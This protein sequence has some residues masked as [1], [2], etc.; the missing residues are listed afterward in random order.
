MVT[1]I[2]HGKSHQGVG[3]AGQGH[4]VLAAQ[5]LTHL[6]QQKVGLEFVAKLKAVIVF[7]SQAGAC[8]GIC[9]IADP[10]PQL[11]AWQRLKLNADRNIPADARVATVGNF[12][13]AKLVRVEQVRLG[14]G[15]FAGVISVAGGEGQVSLEDGCGVIVCA[16]EGDVAEQVF[17]AGIKLE[18][19]VCLSFS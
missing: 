15:Q 2:E 17:G 10:R 9:A 11:V 1:V 4:Q 5:G 6:C 7:E 14:L 18:L 16:M 3:L 8:A 12:H 13:M 19:D